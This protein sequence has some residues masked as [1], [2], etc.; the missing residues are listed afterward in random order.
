M[1]ERARFEVLVSAAL[2]EKERCRYEPSSERLAGAI[3]DGGV[4]G[5]LRVVR[6]ES[7]DVYARLRSIRSGAGQ[8][9]CA[10]PC[11]PVPCLD[12]S[13]WPD[14]MRVVLMR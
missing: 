11:T 3:G 5:H 12:L 9:A 1:D 10:S 2:R 14:A 4:K 8:N 6:G 13:G 7:R